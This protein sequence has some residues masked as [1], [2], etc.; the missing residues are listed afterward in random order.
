VGLA[1]CVRF[2]SSVCTVEWNRSTQSGR[3]GTLMSRDFV[4]SFPSGVKAL[5]HLA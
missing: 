5:A 1:V 3:S 4:K 2:Y